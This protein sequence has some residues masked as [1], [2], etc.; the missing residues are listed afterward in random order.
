MT[1]EKIFKAEENE[2]NSVQSF[3]LSCLENLHLDIKLINQIR[4]AVEEIFVN[5]ACYA[6]VNKGNATVR[7]NVKE[8]KF[9]IVFIDS[10]V[11]F[12][13]LEKQDPNTKA[14]ANERGIGG[15]G[16]FMVKNLMDDV[17]YKFENNQN[18][19]TLVKKY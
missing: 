5:I 2:L 1:Q 4:I 13:P 9:E 10:G 7:V 19:L 15:L 16:I 14:S 6:Y 11:K 8:D 17:T 12:N 18:I 3:V